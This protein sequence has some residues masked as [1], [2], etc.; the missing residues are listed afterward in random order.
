M[1]GRSRGW[2]IKL[3]KRN[4]KNGENKNRENKGREKKSRGSVFRQLVVSYIVFAVISVITLYLCMFT[5]LALIGGG[6]LETLTPYN[7]VDDEGNLGDIRSF[8]R[9]GGWIEKLD[10][11]YHVEEVYGEKQDSVRSYTVEDISEYLCTDHM[12]ETDSPARDYRGF[13]KPVRI[14]GETVWYLMK[15]SRETLYMVYSYNAGTGSPA[16]KAVS[17]AFLLFA[18]AFVVNCFLMSAYLSRKIKRPLVKITEGMD[19][20]RRGTGAVRLDFQAQKE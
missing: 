2:G 15:I 4:H 7:L 6:R 1:S 20:V 13:L 19:Q 9:I 3:K 5:L 17:A 10:S 18:A 11:R 12:V 8:T 14:K 16:A